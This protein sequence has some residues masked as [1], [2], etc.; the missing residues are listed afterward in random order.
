MIADNL[1]N[2]K[3]ANIVITPTTKDVEDIPMS[4]EDIVKNNYMTKEECD[5]IYKKSLELFKCG[6]L[7]ADKLVI[8]V[9]TKYEFGRDN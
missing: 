6:E 1:K 5:Y 2:Q 8:L 3:L 9:D 7:I 4:K